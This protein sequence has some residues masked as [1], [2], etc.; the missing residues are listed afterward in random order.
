MRGLSEEYGSWKIACMRRRKASVAAL[1]MAPRSAPSN[2][3]A[4]AVGGI[5][6]RRQRATVLLPQPD[7]PTRPSASPLRMVKLTPST[8][9]TW[10]TARRNTIP[11]VTGKCFFRSRTSTRTCSLPATL[12]SRARP[13][14]GGQGSPGAAGTPPGSRRSSAGEVAEEQGEARL[15]D[16]E[17]DQEQGAGHERERRRVDVGHGGAGRGH[18][19]HDEQEQ[20]ERGRG[21]ADLEREEDDHAEPDQIEA[22]GL[23]EREEDRHGDQHHRE[24]VHEHAEH[25]EHA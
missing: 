9:F 18:A 13:V 6:F 16:Q 20:A 3:M 17:G 24:L 23:G 22:E 7:S 21:E 15:P 5:S 19:A 4:P 8:A 25:P 1:S 2:R 14:P 10:P 11:R 12:P